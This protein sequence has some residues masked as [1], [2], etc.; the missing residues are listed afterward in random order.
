M[1]FGKKWD[2]DPEWPSDMGGPRGYKRCLV[3]KADYANDFETTGKEKC[4][5]ASRKGMKK[6][7]DEQIRKLMQ[8]VTSGNAESS[9]LDF[10]AI[11]SHVTIGMA[12]RVQEEDGRVVSALQAEG[13]MAPSL[14]KLMEDVQRGGGHKLFQK[15]KAYDGG[16]ENDEKKEDNGSEGGDDPK[17]PN[18]KVKGGRKG[19]TPKD[20]ED[21]QDAQKLAKLQRGNIW[22]L[23]TLEKD[24]KDTFERMQESKGVQECFMCFWHDSYRGWVGVG[25]AG[26]G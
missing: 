5:E 17:T 25:W 2:S 20:K 13:V 4:I 14:S 21:W 26:L 12:S 24:A 10:E 19:N 3:Y 7:S 18:K 11:R 1:G 23:E 22:E 8:E 16:P 9:S 6:A 15:N